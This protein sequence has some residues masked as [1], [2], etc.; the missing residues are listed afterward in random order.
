MPAAS[1][2]ICRARD[3]SICCSQNASWLSPAAVRSGEVADVRR[4]GSGTPSAFTPI[5]NRSWGGATTAEI[6][7]RTSM[8][9]L[10]SSKRKL[11]L[12]RETVMPLVRDD[13]GN[14]NGGADNR[15]TRDRTQESV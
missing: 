15:D 8:Q 7:G 1:T 4:C 13:L 3:T 2:V 5:T 9:N 14:V 12:N 6:Q 10:K 11:Q